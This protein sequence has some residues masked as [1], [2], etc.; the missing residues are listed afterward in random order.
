MLPV[1]ISGEVV[2]RFGKGQRELNCRI[3]VM[4][5]ITHE[6]SGAVKRQCY[7]VLQVPADAGTLSSVTILKVLTILKSDVCL[8]LLWTHDGK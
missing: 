2:R 6:V 7:V 8:Y 5:L 1:E 3:E 4:Q